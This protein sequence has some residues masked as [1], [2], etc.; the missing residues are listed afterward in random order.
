MSQMQEF[1]YSVI[2]YLPSP[3][4]GELGD[5][6]TVAL[7]VFPIGDHEPAKLYVLK[8]RLEKVWAFGCEEHVEFVSEA[9][10]WIGLRLSS[11]A[12][13]ATSFKWITA[14]LDFAQAY[15]LLRQYGKL[16][17]IPLTARSSTQASTHPSSI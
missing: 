7:V 13:P 4:L 12:N 10:D 9:L 3:E 11:A 16:K 1:G 2:Y 14:L 15:W 5:R 17:P 6:L 8:N